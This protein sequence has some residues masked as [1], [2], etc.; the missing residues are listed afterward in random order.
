MKNLVIGGVIGLALGLLVFA[1]YY[2][3][4]IWAPYAADNSK[5]FEGQMVVVIGYQPHREKGEFR[6]SQTSLGQVDTLKAIKEKKWD[7]QLVVWCETPEE[8][9]ETRDAVRKALG[10]QPN[11]DKS[12]SGSAESE[13][14]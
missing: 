11:E 5:Q 2:H 10:W 12:N 7:D 3:F 4:S 9:K 6:W 14:K 1:F 13:S 8:A